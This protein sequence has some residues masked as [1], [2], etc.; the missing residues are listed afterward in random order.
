MGNKKVD[1]EFL[2]QIVSTALSVVILILVLV[3]WH[4]RKD[5]FGN[6]GRRDPGPPQE[7]GCTAMQEVWFPQ[8]GIPVHH[9]RCSIGLPPF[10]AWHG[11]KT[12]G[13]QSKEEGSRRMKFSGPGASLGPFRW[14]FQDCGKLN[15]TGPASL[16]EAP[17]W[18]SIL[19]SRIRN[20]SWNSSVYLMISPIITA[21]NSK[22]HYCVSQMKS[23]MGISNDF[24]QHWEIYMQ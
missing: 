5:V 23:S 2:L 12:E 19:S 6:G 16:M 11:R 18:Y 14:F 4:G 22:N 24:F 3:K 21:L 20:L 15:T 13:L 7:H 10:E 17:I 1:W 9:R 8:G